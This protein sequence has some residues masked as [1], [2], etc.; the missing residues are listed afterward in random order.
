MVN[1]GTILIEGLIL[2]FTVGTSCLLTCLPILLAHISADHP[3]FKNGL[4]SSISFN[5]GRLIAYIIYAFI[6]GLTGYLLDEFIAKSV[7]LVLIFSLILIIFLIMYGL[8]LVIGEEYF[9]SLSKKVCG[10]TQK[11]QSSLVLGF[12]IGLF[13]CGPLFYI[14]GQAVILGTENLFL[15][16]FFFLIFWVGTTVYILIAGV[17]IGGGASF[18]RRRERVERIRWISGFILI[19]L[20]LFHLF[21]FLNLF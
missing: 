13:P 8:S 3:G 15:S 14:I 6:F 18:I 21:Q 12:L 5:F 10:F 4:L 17:S 20:G 2:G 7:P 9:P 16:F 19:I 1:I 11:H